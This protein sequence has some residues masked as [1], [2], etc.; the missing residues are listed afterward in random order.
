MY[1]NYWERSSFIYKERSFRH[2]LQHYSGTKRT[3][4]F[5]C[6]C[7]FIG[8]SAVIKYQLLSKVL[9][10]NGKSRFDQLPSGS[11][12]TCP[13]RSSSKMTRNVFGTG[14]QFLTVHVSDLFYFRFLH[15]SIYCD[16]IFHCITL[17]NTRLAYYIFI[18]F[19]T[20]E[21]TSTMTEC[22]MTEKS[23]G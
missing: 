19:V 13:I 11:S 14:L 17:I 15:A 9:S 6:A 7:G 21:F 12:S 2:N 8:K 18:T 23:S 3:Y 20:V 5:T 1:S 22:F 16:S 10:I 4:R